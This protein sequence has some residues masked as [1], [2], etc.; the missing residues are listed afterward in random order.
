MNQNK[1]NLDT[2]PKYF[3]QS[4]LIA[5]SSDVFVL[6]MNLGDEQIAYALTPEHMKQ[7]SLSINY[8]VAEFEKTSRPINTNWSPGIQSPIQASELNSGGDKGKK[9]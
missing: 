1:L 6:V 4:T 3:C 7:L 2:L 9:K 5:R 8:N